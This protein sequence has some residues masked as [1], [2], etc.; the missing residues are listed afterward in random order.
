MSPMWKQ[1]CTFQLRQSVIKEIYDC[2]PGI[3]RTEA[4]VRL[5]FWWPSLDELIETCVK[6]CK[7]C[8]VHQSISEL[9]SNN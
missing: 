2:H 3:V 1:G 8:Q 9:A 7:T 5:Y 4:L 6:Q